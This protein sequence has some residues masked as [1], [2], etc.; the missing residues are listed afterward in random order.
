[1]NWK[2]AWILTRKDLAEFKKQK[3]VI[4]S[5]IMMPLVLGVI[6]PIFMILPTITLAPLEDVWEIEGLIET[7]NFKEEYLDNWTN[8]TLENTS[9]NNIVLSHAEL[10]NSQIKNCV[11]ISC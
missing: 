11:I 2:N 6:M 8:Q 10:K 3:L 5:I 7:G 1:M 9:L 4:G